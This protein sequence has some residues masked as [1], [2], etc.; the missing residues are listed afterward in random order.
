MQ[1]SIS[2]LFLAITLAVSV[3]SALAEDWPPYIKEIISE[4]SSGVLGRSSMAQQDALAFAIS[5]TG[6]HRP[7]FNNGSM[8]FG[9]PCGLSDE[10][11]SATGFDLYRRW[12]HGADVYD[13]LQ[14]AVLKLDE[15]CSKGIKNVRGYFKVTADNALKDIYRAEQTRKERE[16]EAYETSQRL[17]ADLYHEIQGE[18]LPK[19]PDFRPIEFAYSSD[20]IAQ[21]KAYLDSVDGG[22]TLLHVADILSKRLSSEQLRTLYARTVEELGLEE[23]AIR[24][25]LKMSTVQ[26][27][28]RSAERVL[29]E[30][31]PA[32]KA[33]VEEQGWNLRE[34]WANPGAI[35]AVIVLA[36]GALLGLVSLSR[37]RHKKAN[38]TWAETQHRAS[39]YVPKASAPR[40][41]SHGGSA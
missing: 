10:D 32:T 39:A 30:E 24:Y 4:E 1:K 36:I 33:V 12:R 16:R 29:A 25:G 35:G 11:Y 40:S 9:Y 22:A 37:R 28:L 20:Q 27:Q 26:S 38:S 15:A 18:D 23:I 31:F 17:V 21:L 7:S 34:F 6:P 13:A 8:Q 5:M 2:V 3:Q 14:Q 41:L 19:L